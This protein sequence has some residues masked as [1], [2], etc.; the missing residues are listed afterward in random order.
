MEITNQSNTSASLYF[1]GDI[2]GSSQ[3]EDYKECYPDDKCPK[4][5]RD[6][7]DE[8]KDVETLDIHINSGGGSVFGGIA[9]YNLLKAHKA[10]K[11][12]HID[13]IAASIAS[14]IAMAGDK[15][16]LPKNA[17]FMIHKP[18]NGYFFAAMNADQL[19]KDAE[20]LDSCQ[21]AI[22]TSYMD[23]VKDGVTREQ[24]EDL[25]NEETWLVG[26]EAEQYF[27]FEIEESVE[28]VACTSVFFDKYEKTPK[29]LKPQTNIV[30][31]EELA[32]I[33]YEKIK[34]DS[35]EQLKN[36]ILKD[37]EKFSN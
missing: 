29:D 20:T 17:T 10:Y 21:K 13:G 37:L 3:S 7:L 24:I 36:E 6:F 14:V 35:R 12:V 2:L 32:N 5:V 15:I 16:V 30:D 25:V 23:K 11:T 18:M 34:A 26:D 1:Y 8:I 22:I 33:V 4:D 9:I 19:R 28:A 31:T 27:D